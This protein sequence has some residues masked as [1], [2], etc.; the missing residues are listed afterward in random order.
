MVQFKKFYPE[1]LYH[2]VDVLTKYRPIAFEKLQS[3][4]S[5][6][7]LETPELILA[8]KKL[9]GEA[10]LRRGFV[11]K[12]DLIKEVISSKKD[13]YQYHS[14]YFGVIDKNTN[15]VVAVARQIQ[16]DGKGKQLPVLS[17]IKINKTY[18]HLL[19]SEIV[20]ISAFVK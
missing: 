3:R 8:A 13:P 18:D 12:T 9:H 14:L 11:V 16:Y 10:Y 19:T 15:E 6:T 1:R 5:A 17:K 2:Y 20:E 4:Y 7:L